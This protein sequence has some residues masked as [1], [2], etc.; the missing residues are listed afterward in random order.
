MSDKYTIN[1]QVKTIILNMNA[2]TENYFKYLQAN[3]IS[4]PGYEMKD[5]RTFD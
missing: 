3:L 4:C 1:S 2:I 5:P